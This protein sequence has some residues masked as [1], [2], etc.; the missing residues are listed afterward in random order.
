VDEDTL[1]IVFGHDATTFGGASGSPVF[2]WGAANQPAVGLHF[3]GGT[4]VSNYAIAIAVPRV[5]DAL[6]SL[7]VPM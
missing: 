3:A 5:V 2:A 4:E 7:G 1:K 6:V